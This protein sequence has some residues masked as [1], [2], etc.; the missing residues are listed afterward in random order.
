MIVTIDPDTHNTKQI[1]YNSTDNYVITRVEWTDDIPNDHDIVSIRLET[2]PHNLRKVHILL[3]NNRVGTILD[4]LPGQNLLEQLMYDPQ[5]ILP[6]SKCRYMKKHIDFCYEN[7]MSEFTD[8]S[9]YYYHEEKVSK[10]V[11]SNDIVS[12]YDINE[13]VVRKGKQVLRY[14]TEIIRNLC[15]KSP[16]IVIETKQNECDPSE[17]EEFHEVNIWHIHTFRKDTYAESEIVRYINEYKLC[18]KNGE[19]VIEKFRSLEKGGKME[20]KLA[21]KINFYHGFAGLA[22]YHF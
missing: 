5:E 8:P 14:D 12:F 9:T 13:D 10:R 20:G 11:L 1:M 21:N 2:I 16:G 18:L 4:F 22:C 6:L 7:D 17:N 3:G 19:D 15:F